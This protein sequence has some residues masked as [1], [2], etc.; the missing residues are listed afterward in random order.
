VKLVI[1]VEI[2]NIVAHIAFKFYPDASGTFSTA[3]TSAVR[4]ACEHDARGASFLQRTVIANRLVETATI[5]LS[6]RD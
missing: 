3:S 1:N 2:W 4:W 5:D 6:R